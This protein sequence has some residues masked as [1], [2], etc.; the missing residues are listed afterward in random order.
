MNTTL[1]C[2][3]CGAS[4]DAIA[5]PIMRTDMCPGCRADLHACRLCRMFDTG[6][7]NACREPIADPVTDKG[8]ANFCGY[9][10]PRPGAYRATT[11]D[12]AHARLAALFGEA[13]RPEAAEES[14]DELARK[15]LEALFRQK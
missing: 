11:D 4:L 6:V 2:W 8:R 1:Q 13:P 3:K 10:E 14:A 7:A 9:F 12:G 5:V 15:A